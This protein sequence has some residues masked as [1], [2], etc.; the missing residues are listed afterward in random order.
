M[1][2][3]K[4]ILCP[5]DFS[6][7][8][9]RSVDYATEMAK[10]LNAELHLVHAYSDPLDSIPFGRANTSGAAAADPELISKAQQ[11]RTSEA[12]RL[13][14]LCEEH[15]VTTA[16]SEIAGEARVVICDA[17]KQTESDLI[18]MGTHGRT[19]AARALIGS[20]AER[21]VRTAPCPVLV[22]P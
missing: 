12:Q 5:V 8:S 18:I 2:Q 11:A 20:V 3:I 10:V 7:C 4:K 22:V 16:V 17:A 15:G 14:A 1:P 9:Q 21:V 13:Q 19:G 6:K